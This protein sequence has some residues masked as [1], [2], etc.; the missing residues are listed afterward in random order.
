MLTQ[1]DR[2]SG[3]RDKQTHATPPPKLCKI[4]GVEKPQ[5]AFYIWQSKKTGRIYQK[6]QCDDCFR[7]AARA[8]YERLP[9]EERRAKAREYRHRKPEKQLEYNR[10]YNEKYPGKKRAENLVRTELRSRRWVKRPCSCCGEPNAH[11][12]H[13]SYAEGFELC[14]IWLC[15]LCHRHEHIRLEAIGLDPFTS[16]P[17]LL[18]AD[19][20]RRHPSA[21]EAPR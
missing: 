9:P 12:H 3:T 1:T 16:D 18:E 17:A 4:C 15:A 11:A 13:Y 14:V 20:R 5:H 2:V 10:R 6:S 7:K 19:A 8:W 21:F